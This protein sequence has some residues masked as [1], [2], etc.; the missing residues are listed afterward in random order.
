MYI[1]ELLVLFLTCRLHLR[2][3][4]LIW[5]PLIAIPSDHQTLFMFEHV[6]FH[7]TLSFIF[8]YDDSYI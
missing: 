6:G 5:V 7:V 2:L 1:S 4:Q 3:T 8:R